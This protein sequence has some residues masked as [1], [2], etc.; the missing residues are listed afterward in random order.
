MNTFTPARSAAIAA[1]T[2]TA[3]LTAGCAN[4]S[5]EQKGT[6]KG[7]GIG[8]VVGATAGVLIGD[9]KRAAATGAAVGAVGGAIAGNIWSKKME[10]KKRALEQQT[11]GTGIDVAQ[12]PNNEL[13]VNVPADSGF[14][15][16]RS[17]VRPQLRSVL[18]TFAAGLD[19]NMRVRVIGHTDSTGSDAINDPLSLDRAQSVRDYLA[20]R[21]VQPAR[22]ETRGRGSKEPV[23]DNSTEAGRAANRRVEIF[24]REPEQAAAPTQPRS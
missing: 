8:A 6:A 20:A 14:A 11:Q 22:V 3:L 17:D 23:A 18:D 15:T 7:A 5:E 10:E 4:M 24:L 21:G 13:K 19:P 9:N 16:G 12:T 2:A 1:L